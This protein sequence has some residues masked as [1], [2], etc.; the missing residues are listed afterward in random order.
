MFLNWTKTQDSA[1]SRVVLITEIKK[2]EGSTVKE[3]END[4]FEAL[5]AALKGVCDAFFINYLIRAFLFFFL[6]V[7]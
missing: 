4:V 1:G 3:E 6:S 5:L 7:A 2:T